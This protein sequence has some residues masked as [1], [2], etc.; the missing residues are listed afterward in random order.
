ML[1]EELLWDH[2]QFTVGTLPAHRFASIIFAWGNKTALNHPDANN[3]GLPCPLVFVA[4]PLIRERLDGG[5]PLDLGLWVCEDAH[6]QM[7]L[8]DGLHLWY[9]PQF[10]HQCL[11]SSALLEDALSIDRLKP[12]ATR[13]AKEK[14]KE[15]SILLQREGCAC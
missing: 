4:P 7:T 6:L 10:A 2:L 14:Q 12:H 1:H 3:H 13:V 9:F 11:A 8:A 5:E 15:A